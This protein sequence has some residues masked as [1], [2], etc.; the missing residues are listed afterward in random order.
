MCA[1]KQSSPLVCQSHIVV[2]LTGKE[3][4]VV[5][6]IHPV[7]LQRLREDCVLS[8]CVCVYIR[9]ECERMCKMW[10]VYGNECFA[11]VA[12]LCAF[13]KKKSTVYTVHRMI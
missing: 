2:D 11:C 7:R 1:G 9:R 8:A 4:E 5:F 6:F 13:K 10:N 12:Y 3:C